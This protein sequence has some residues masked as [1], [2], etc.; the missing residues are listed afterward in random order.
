MR[1]V[2]FTQYI[3]AKYDSEIS[4]IESKQNFSEN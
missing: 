2:K 1:F 4:F 3:H